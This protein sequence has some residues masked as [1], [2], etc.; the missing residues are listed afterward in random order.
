MNADDKWPT[1][2]ATWLVAFLPDA[3]RARCLA[4]ARERVDRMRERLPV[5]LV[6]DDPPFEVQR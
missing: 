6:V 5:T 1:L 2:H 4:A 3:T